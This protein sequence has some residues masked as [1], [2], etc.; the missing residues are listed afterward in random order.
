MV[1]YIQVRNISFF[2]R[3]NM[4]ST[5]FTAL[6]SLA[7]A[8]QL[9]VKILRYTALTSLKKLSNTVLHELKQ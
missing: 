8:C 2:Q 1:L 6:T 4:F 7:L 3:F 5:Y 9:D